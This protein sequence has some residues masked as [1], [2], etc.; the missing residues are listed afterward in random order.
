MAHRM[1]IGGGA[2]HVFDMDSE[3]AA[4]TPVC[5]PMADGEATGSFMAFS[6][7]YK[8]L[9]TTAKPGAAAFKVDPA[10]GALEH[11][12]TVAT[13]IPGATDPP[14]SPPAA[15]HHPLPAC[16]GAGQATRTSPSRGPAA[17]RWSC[18]R[19]TAGAA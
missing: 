15:P 1:Y 9:Y 10:S 11:I 8:Q 12:N 4:L 2:I 17:R 19:P 6:D 13:T 18:W 3:S 5:A 7:D 16:G 14:P